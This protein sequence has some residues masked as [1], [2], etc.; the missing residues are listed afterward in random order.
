MQSFGLK[1]GQP[2]FVACSGGPDSMAL[3]MLAANWARRYHHPFRIVFVHHGLRQEAGD[4]IALAHRQLSARGILCETLYIADPHAPDKMAPHQPPALQ[5]W[6][7][8]HRYRLLSHAART[9]NAVVLLGHHRDDQ[10]ETVAMRLGKGSGVTGLA[11]MARARIHHQVRFLRPLLD[12]NRENLSEFLAAQGIVPAY[13]PSN[14]NR[15]FERVRTRQMLAERPDLKE[16]LLRLS[17]VCASLTACLEK[18]L[19]KWASDHI[20][21]I[22]PLYAAMPKSAYLALP[23]EAR[24]LLLRDLLPALGGRDHPPSR[25]AVKDLDTAISQGYDRTLSYVQVKAGSTQLVLCAEGGRTAPTPLQMSP[26]ESAVFDGRWLVSSNQSGLVMRLTR[27]AYNSL[28][29]Q[30]ALYNQLQS[31]P[32]SV[33]LMIPVLHTLDDRLWTPHFK[34]VDA[35]PAFNDLKNATTQVVSDRN[36]NN[37]H[38][39]VSQNPELS[40][41]P[42]SRRT[43]ML[44]FDDL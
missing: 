8:M 9:Q 2:L 31:L 20:T 17:K 6:A 35:F 3:A 26:G 23:A 29:R 28:D 19:K 5:E 44:N 42:L 10:A 41:S 34:D 38:R 15:L 40:L 33:R 11:G 37:H 13:D 1:A 25:Q 22:W 30:G 24:Y 16:Q 7:R 27:D 18:P 21:A 39:L 36:L 4:E 12:E 14:Q 43:M 32:Y